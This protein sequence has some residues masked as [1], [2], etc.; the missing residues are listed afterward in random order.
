MNNASKSSFLVFELLL[1]PKL[2][3]L[4]TMPKI[5]DK[6]RG[7][8]VY[9]TMS[10]KQEFTCANDF[11]LRARNE[12]VPLPKTKL[13]K[14]LYFLHGHYLVRTG[15]ALF[16]E[17]FL[18]YDYGPVLVSIYKRTKAYMVSLF[19]LRDPKLKDTYITDEATEFGKTYVQIFD[20]VWNKYK[21]YTASELVA[22]THA[23]GG[24]WQLARSRGDKYI[25][26]DLIGR[27][28]KG[29]QIWKAC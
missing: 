7:K 21:G 17:K 9:S 25:S 26:D 15:E 22:L 2:L 29:E 3:I 23:E 4:I 20:Y 14:M 18:A 13:I 10:P 8:K 11:I 5:F 28:F 19:M 27:Y 16:S 6:Q 1:H 12:G 24:P